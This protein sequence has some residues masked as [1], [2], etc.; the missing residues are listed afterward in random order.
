MNCTDPRSDYFFKTGG[1]KRTLW[2][3]LQPTETLDRLH[4]L[5]FHPRLQL[6]GML[7]ELCDTVP[8]KDIC[9]D[10]IR[11]GKSP[12]EYDEMGEIT[13]LKTIDLKNGFIDYDDALN[14]SEDFFHDHPSA[15]VHT[16]DLL[17]ASTGYG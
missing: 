15:H 9:I 3:A 12:Q 10:V 13:I 7:G 14:V 4:Y 16:G 1:E 6:L 11:R 8:L 5:F 2:F 17:I